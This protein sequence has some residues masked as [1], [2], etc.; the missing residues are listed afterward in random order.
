MFVPIRKVYCPSYSG[1]GFASESTN[2]CVHHFRNDVGLDSSPA[3]RSIQPCTELKYRQGF[4][5]EFLLE[6]GEVYIVDMPLIYIGHTIPAGHRLRINILST[7]LPLYDPNPN[8]GEPIAL[9]TRVQKARVTV[10]HD[11]V[12]SSYV[13]LP[14]VGF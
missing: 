9:A 7:E 5:K 3:L 8:T 12:M 13:T 6:P 14:M 10:H 4:D 11:D 1:C 2:S